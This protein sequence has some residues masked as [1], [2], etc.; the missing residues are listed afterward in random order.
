MNPLANFTTPDEL[1]PKEFA[2]RCNL[3]RE[4]QRELAAL[5]D[6]LADKEA[7][8]AKN[9]PPSPILVAIL[10]HL[11][12]LDT[13][14]TDVLDIR[15]LVEYNALSLFNDTAIVNGFAWSVAERQYINIQTGKRLSN[16]RV[17]ERIIQAPDSDSEPTN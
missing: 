16:A 9:A 5:Q 15:Q 6:A 3:L 11:G 7:R 2:Y 17:L 1:L 13:N 14:R 8:E 12:I 4:A 10:E